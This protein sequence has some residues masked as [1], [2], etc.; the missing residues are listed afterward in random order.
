VAYIPIFSTNMIIVFLHSKCGSC[1]YLHWRF[2]GA[3]S[4]NWLYDLSITYETTEAMSMQ[5]T[6]LHF[7]QWVRALPSC[8]SCEVLMSAWITRNLQCGVV[9]PSLIP[10]LQGNLTMIPNFTLKF[11]ASQQGNT[12]DS[13][14]IIM[15]NYFYLEQNISLSTSAYCYVGY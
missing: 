5:M 12:T 3:C 11:D 8:S 1:D 14:S 6:N 15:Q 13:H 10:K 4:S 7:C 2:L 9:S